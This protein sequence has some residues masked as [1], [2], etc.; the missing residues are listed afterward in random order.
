LLKDKPAKAGV[1]DT[2]GN[3]TA[4]P[5]RYAYIWPFNAQGVAVA[6]EKKGGPYG[7]IDRHGIPLTKFKYDTITT[8]TEGYAPVMT[9]KGWGLL[10]VSGKEVIPPQYALMDTLAEGLIAVKRRNTLATDR[11]HYV[12]TLNRTVFDTTYS[13][14]KRFRGGLAEVNGNDIMNRRGEK[15]PLSGQRL[16]AFSEG[17]FILQDKRSAFMYCA[18]RLGNNLFN[19]DF[20]EIGKFEN[21]I[22]FVKRGGLW[23]GVNARGLYVIP[24]KYRALIPQKDGNIIAKAPLFYGL[25]DRTGKIVVPPMYDRIEQM[26]NLNLSNEVFRVELGEKVGYFRSDGTEVVPLKY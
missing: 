4:L 12:D 18:D 10:S 8:F 19:R 22:V 21:G 24:P 13:R 14:A 3:Y 20:L 6:C 11:W 7:L 26:L 15:L 1:I 17:I 9:V 25:R 16:K 2:A 5:D 23:G